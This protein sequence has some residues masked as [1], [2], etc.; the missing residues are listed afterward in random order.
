MIENDIALWIW[1]IQTYGLSVCTAFGEYYALKQ[2]LLVHMS[3][4]HT[5][6]GRVSAIV[7]KMLEGLA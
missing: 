1:E 5:E 4:L 2:R 3:H 7:S 6:P